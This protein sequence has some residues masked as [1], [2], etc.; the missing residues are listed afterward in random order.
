MCASTSAWA[1]CAAKSHTNIPI[2]AR[3]ALLIQRDV[4]TLLNMLLAGGHSVV[5]GRLAGAFK[6]I[7]KER[8]ADE[9][10]KTM[11]AAGYV[12]RVSDPFANQCSMQ[13]NHREH[14]PYVN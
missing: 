7:N 1:S 9:I 2:E 8:F 3:E 11:R 12:I 14:S 10:I 5:A 13:L 6:N 4:S